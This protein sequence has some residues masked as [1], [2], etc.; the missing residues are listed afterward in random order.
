[1]SSLYLSAVASMAA[2]MEERNDDL[3]LQ[4]I[5]SEED[6]QELEFEELDELIEQKS[7]E[8]L[9]ILSIL[10]L[11]CPSLGLQVYW[12]LLQ[13][14]GTPYL[15]SLGL[16]GASISIIWALGP[17][18]GAF[19]QPILG[20]LS[21][22]F[23]HPLCRRKPF[24]IAGAAVV[25]LAT[26]TMAC[27]QELTARFIP[28][29]LT[30]PWQPRALAVACLVV[31][32]FALG[33]YSVGVRAI[34]VDNCP[35]SQQFGAAAWSMRWN[36]LGSAALS[37]AGF[38]A[39]TGR[40]ET[41]PAVTFRALACVA[42]VCSAA[43][44]GL[45]C[46]FAP[47]ETTPRLRPQGSG[48]RS[49]LSLCAPG[50]LVRRWR[51]LPPLTNKV[52]NIQLLAWC[53]WF[54]MLY[55]MSTQEIPLVARFE[56]SSVQAWQRGLDAKSVESRARSYPLYASLFFSFGTVSSTLLLLLLNASSSFPKIT[57]PRIWLVSELVAT[58]SLLLT[59]FLCSRHASL[60]LIFL[61]GTTWTVTMW[62][63]FALI[64]AELAELRSGVAGV[65][66]LH[67]LAVSLPQIA[68]ALVCAAV[69]GGLRLVGVDGGAV[70]L[71]RLAA[72]PVASS[73]WLTWR[74]DGA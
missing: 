12:F 9:S 25:S 61:M 66:G 70:W 30:S 74:L 44:V 24:M 67:N 13:S 63:P 27:A 64:N 53:G 37:T 59:F 72:V 57:L 31:I 8:E 65:Q 20:N 50:S 2:S 69:L 41:D 28:D 1:Q 60:T 58:A 42:A 3:P 29:T 10:L 46:W 16:D 15:R 6:G 35:P 32:L 49:V 18:F 39:V 21:D 17:I 7:P 5:P 52:C 71:L 51:R 45:V 38:F 33:A 4:R 36:V 55:Y 43:T 23:P 56:M 73:A 48:L 68:S 14:S 26:F 54:P 22:E 34:V 62:V 47:P 40:P 11:T 19:V